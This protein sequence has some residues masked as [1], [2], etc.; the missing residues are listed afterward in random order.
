MN[1][2]YKV[3]PAE[4]IHPWKSNLSEI[5]AFDVKAKSLEEHLVF[6]KR[7]E[8]KG[9]RFLD[10]T[11]TF[12]HEVRLSLSSKD[13]VAQYLINYISRQKTYSVMRRN[14]QTFA[15]NFCAFLAG[16]KDVEPY[17]PINRI[18]YHNQTHY[19]LYEPSMYE[20]HQ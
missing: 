2:F 15:A 19:F 16:K 13:H 1:S 4:M 11:V 18:Q 12:E 9:A 20:S 14:C 17:H 8:G 5:R 7:F 10:I 6:M 3:L